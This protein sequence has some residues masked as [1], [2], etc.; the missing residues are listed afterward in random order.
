M[1]HRGCTIPASTA[2]EFHPRRGRMPYR[3]QTRTWCLLLA[4]AGF[5][6]AGAKQYQTTFSAPVLHSRET[7][8][9]TK[10]GVTIA[11]VPITR[12]NMLQFPEVARMVS[13]REPDPRAPHPTTGGG[14]ATPPQLQTV[15]RSGPVAL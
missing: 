12:E 10:D 15:V 1:H 7:P 13:W 3:Y 9:V 2:F 5:A 6:C 8:E 4:A 14:Q 11:A